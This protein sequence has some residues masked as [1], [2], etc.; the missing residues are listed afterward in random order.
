MFF[1]I[2]GERTDG[3]LYLMNAVERGAACL[4]VSAWDDAVAG[5]VLKAAAESEVSPRQPLADRDRSVGRRGYGCRRGQDRQAAP[6]PLQPARGRHHGQ[7]RQD[8][9]EGHGRPHP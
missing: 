3:H 9:G 1:A 6:K 7:C 5:Q 8:D 2:K 4:L